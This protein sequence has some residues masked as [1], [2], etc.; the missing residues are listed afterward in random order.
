[1]NA[2]SVAEFAFAATWQDLPEAVRTRIRLA[3]ID[4]G[5]CLVAGTM[6]AA[7]RA[8]ARAAAGETG[9]LLKA[10]RDGVAASALDFDDGHYQGGGI[11]L[12]SL[13]LPTL[14][15]LM[16]PAT[17]GNDLLTALA[18]GYEVAIRAGF[19]MAPRHPGDEYHTSGAP[20]ALGAAVAGA[21]LTGLDADGIH[22][23]LRIASTH[24]PLAYLQLP[25][26]KE[27]IGW[28]AAS[29]IAAVR[30]AAAGFDDA[31]EALKVPPPLGL[32]PTPFDGAYADDPFV[33]GLGRDWHAPAAYFKPYACCR[34]IHAALDGLQDILSA[35]G[36]RATDIRAIRVAVPQNICGLDYLPP[37]SPEHA[38]FSIPFALAA[39]AVTGRVG[40]AELSE[41]GLSDAAV[42]K[43]AQR[44]T[45]VGDAALDGTPVADGYPAAITVEA[46]GTEDQRCIFHAR[47]GGNRPWSADDVNAKFLANAR[48]VMTEAQARAL[49]NMLQSL[50]TRPVPAALTQMG[51]PTPAAK[52]EKEE[53]S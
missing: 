25:M 45:I 23:A 16:T 48:R 49:L 31:P 32:P 26:V 6:T 39:L 44:I 42:R 28:G 14:L 4:T 37:A 51:Q 8:A 7:A 53:H 47:G 36:W 19:L 35:R 20:A 33:A 34:A 29:A 10:M 30:L 27:T 12:G 21:K 40:P 9:A 52:Q 1:M 41:A 5:G 46:N 24:A 50:D 15:H 2:Y 17:T 43:L 11:H 3:V 38:Q 18:V 13:I 22:R